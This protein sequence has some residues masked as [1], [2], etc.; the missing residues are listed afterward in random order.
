MEQVILDT[1][2]LL[3]FILRDV[4]GQYQT[5]KNFFI[6]AR[7]QKIILIVPQIVIFEIVFN[8]EKYYKFSKSTIIE[9]IKDLLFSSLEIEDAN[10][11]NLA[12][13]IF[14]DTNLEFVDSF[15][16]AK[17]QIKQV[18]IFT[19]DKALKKLEKVAKK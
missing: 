1:N 15:I 2:V 7:A 17:S 3:R 8:L 18:P 10:I 12:I 19:F 5:A 16:I 11:F 4:E 9:K 13:N 6:K 14:K